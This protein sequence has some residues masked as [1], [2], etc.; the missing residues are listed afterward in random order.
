MTANLTRLGVG[1]FLCS[2]AFAADPL[3]EHAVARIGPPPFNHG[4]EIVAALSPDGKWVSTTGCE[5]PRTEP[6]KAD[7]ARLAAARTVVL[8]DAATGERVREW[9]LPD[10]PVSARFSADG[11]R[12]AVNYGRKEPGVAVYDVATG[13]REAHAEKLDARN[14][15][16][17]SDGKGLIFEEGFWGP[18]VRWDIATGKREKEWKQL[19]KASEWVKKGEYVWRTEP[20]VD[21]KYLASLIDL[22]PDYSNVKL[23]PDRL[24]IIPPHVPRPTVLVMTDGAT[25]KPLYR[26]EFE[27]GCLDRFVFSADGKRF[28]VGGEKVTAFDTATGKELFALDAKDV[29]SF[30]VSP[31]GR[32]AVTMT[33]RSEVRLWDLE[34]KKP[35]HE[36]FAGLM[37][38][39]SRLGDEQVFSADGKTVILAT[40]TAVRVFDTATGKERFP[41]VHGT[42]V[43]V[44]YLRRRQDTPHHLRRTTPDLGRDHPGE[45]EGPHH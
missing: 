18:L 36:L 39:S 38:V 28:L 8:W 7:K 32:R 25:D 29:Y 5:E 4:P 21:A 45:T 23:D 40:N 31:D 3:P 20:A 19:E 26:K 2:A 35:T 33:G 14:C 10:G 42:P 11:K 6:G 13:K 16:F 24:V 43:A 1:L 17:T 37:H 30:A 9:E 15:N 27:S 34:T 12:L 41:T 44:R 22:P